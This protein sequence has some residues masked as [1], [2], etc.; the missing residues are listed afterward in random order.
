MRVLVYSE[1]WGKGGIEAFVMNVVRRLQNHGF[2]FDIYS[3]WDWAEISDE[4][5]HSLGIARLTV[6]HGFRPSQLKRL[7]FGALGFRDQLRK[8]RYDAVWINTMN[9]AGFLYARVAEKEGVRIRMVHSHNTDV[10]EGAKT[11]KRIISRIGSLLWG[12]YSTVNVACSQDAGRYLFG[13]R[14]FTVVNNGIDIEKFRF[15]K[16]KRREARLELGVDEQIILLG[17]IGRI[18][19]QKNP[20]FQVGVFAELKKILP[21]SRYLMLGRGD[22]LD[23]V[24]KRSHEL[25]LTSEDVIIHGPVDDPSPYY[26][27]LDA[28]L[29]PSLYEGFGFAK[30]EAQCAGVPVISSNGL[31]AEADVTD[32]VTRCPLDMGEAAWAKELLSRLENRGIIARESYADKV[33]RAGYSVKTAVEQVRRLFLGA[34]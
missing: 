12:K 7:I 15:S 6:F 31:P 2:E 13:K 23:E 28:F 4:N 18:H 21:D 10:G 3:T 11:V 29:M 5:L 26:S 20:L 1:A 22:M 30:L 32:L 24:R 8:S 17:S 19:S 25:G 27:A 14:G 34:R 33:E 16:E 9:G